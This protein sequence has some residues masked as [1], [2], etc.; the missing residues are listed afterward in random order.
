MQDELSPVAEA[1]VSSSPLLLRRTG[2]VL[3][4][5]LLV[6]WLTLVPQG[7]LSIEGHRLAGVLLLTVIWWVTEPI[8]I[9]ATGLLAVTL[10]VILGAVPEPSTGSIAKAVLSSFADPSVFFLLGGMFLARAMTRH[11]LDRRIALGVLTIDWATRSPSRLL[12]AV[13]L[14]VGLVSMWVSNTASTAMVYPVVMGMI[15]VVTSA[16]GRGDFARSP[17]ASSLL[18]ITAFSS[19][20]WG[21]STPIG[22]ATNVV[23]IGFLR[24]PEYL[25]REVDFA[26]WMAVGLPIAFVSFIAAWGV[27]AFLGPAR[28]LDLRGLR[29]Y[30]L[31]ERRSLGPMRRGEANTLFVL[32]CVVTLWV[33]PAIL[34]LA[35]AEEMSLM[36][37]RRFPEEIVALLAPVMLYLLPVDLRT[38]QATL[39][40]DDFLRIDWST[41]L[42]FGSGLSLG[43]L[44]FKTGLAREVGEQTLAMIGTSDPWVIA[45]VGVIGAL[46]LSEFTSNAATAATLIPVIVALSKSANADPLPALFAVTFAASFGSALPVSTMPN[47]IV[48][49]SRLLPIRRMLV[50]GIGVDVVAGI[51]ILAVLYIAFS[52]G[53]KI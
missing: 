18:L 17:F 30:L 5:S 6:G 19:S 43:T 51:V 48:Y 47:A 13:G 44:M 35:G 32:A 4:L 22:T 40:P 16:N 45:A 49:G 31:E 42:L 8:P 38:G 46:T 9:A 7:T 23:A 37:R 36:L 2:L 11:R 39:E 3:G 28:G 21:V 34:S 15:G 10:A 27:L 26:R 50:A 29:S 25:G 12:L 33:L 52:L 41:M 24:Q 1:D 20:I 14:A 53:W